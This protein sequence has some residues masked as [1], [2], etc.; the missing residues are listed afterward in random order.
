MNDP[1]RKPTTKPQLRRFIHH[2]KP[3][4]FLKPL[5]CGAEGAVYHVKIDGN[6]CAIKIFKN[7]K[8]ST[9]SGRDLGLTER[10]KAY[11]SPFAH[12]SRA[13]ARLDSLDENGTWAVRCHGWMQLSDKQFEPVRHLRDYSRWAI[14]K[15]YLPEPVSLDHV[16]EIRRKMSIAR[17]AKLYPEDIQPRNYCGSFLVDLG[18]VKTYPYPKRIWH[19]RRYKEYFPMIDRVVSDWQICTRD[20]DIVEGWVNEVFKRNRERLA[21]AAAEE[22]S[23]KLASTNIGS[24]N[25]CLK[26]QN[27]L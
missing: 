16:P 1:T 23:N 15:D 25:A 12:E 5:G 14:V 20:G 7:W 13:F 2:E 11:A 3:I 27:G 22:E 17:K 8:F 21:A 10:Q 4:Q 26:E 6:E 24:I 9:I 18:R 19:M